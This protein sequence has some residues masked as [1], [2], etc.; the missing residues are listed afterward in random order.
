M[1]E[2]KSV[3]IWGMSNY[4]WL[5]VPLAEEIKKQSGA[6]IHFVCST[7][8]SIVYWKKQDKLE[9]IDTFSTLNHFF[10]EYDNCLDSAEEI[11]KQARCYEDKYNT[12]V[13]DVLQSDRNLGRGFSAGGIGHAKTNLSDKATYIKSV[14]IFNKVVRFWEDY[15]DRISPDLIIGV[16]SGITGKTC[17]A[18]ARGRGISIR[19]FTFSKYQSY[20]YWG[21]DEYY[22]FPEI[23]RN[24]RI[25]EN[26][27]KLVNSEEIRDL[28]RLPWSEKNYQSF[29]LAGSTRV[30]LETIFSQLKGHAYRKYK[31]IIPLGGNYK[32]S[33][34]IRGVYKNYRDI[35]N[36]SKCK[37]TDINDL[38]GK[39]YVFYPL[40][41]EPETALS[42]VS[43]EFNE[44]LALIELVAK[45]LPAG[46]ILVVKDHLGGISRR[47]RDFYA[48]LLDIPN[49]VMVSPSSYALDIAKN[50]KCVIVIASTVGT[51]AVILGIPVI[52]FGIH[53]NF[54]FLPSVH[55][56]ESWKE[57]RPLLSNIC[58]S[59]DTEEDKRRRQED[60]KRYLAT[61]KVSSVDLNGSD[62]ASKNREPATKREVEVI[63]SLLIESLKQDVR[64]STDGVANTTNLN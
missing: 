9:M 8:Q 56:V 13:V 10:S 30:L 26:P 20:F 54:N 16:V 55:V 43:P 57:L 28:K 25:I 38:Q 21:V 64:E 49:V 5:W 12:F 24:F 1:Q 63:F 19:A 17:S 47:P 53:N 51:E 60:G 39:S 42:L 4:N 29:K 23:E 27:D 59:E 14:N 36:L 33:E 61:I 48:T 40:H 7:P 11:Y 50:A 35:R 44:Q 58:C 2:I 6:K 45:N 34:R 62:Y 15:F 3:V 46:T 37:F 32:L 52:S 31:G 18:V 41:V 22:S